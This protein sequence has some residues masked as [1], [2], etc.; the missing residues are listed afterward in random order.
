LELPLSLFKTG[1]NGLMVKKHTMN[2]GTIRFRIDIDFE[3]AD[4]DAVFAEHGSMPTRHNVKGSST[5]TSESVAIY[6]DILFRE[7]NSGNY[8]K[9]SMVES[10][11]LM[12][13]CC[14]AI[15]EVDSD[16]VSFEELPSVI[17][18]VKRVMRSHMNRIGYY[19][20]KTEIRRSIGMLCAG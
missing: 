13:N 12:M 16:E 11:G 18:N 2:L 9:A 20:N 7:N 5:P 4:V 15:F 8:G 14:H 19:R 6:M 17:E 3:G 1:E 10:Y